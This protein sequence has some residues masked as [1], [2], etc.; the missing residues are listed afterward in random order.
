M[1]PGS[2]DT[3]PWSHIVH[4]YRHDGALTGGV[5]EYLAGAL[6]G[7]AAVIVATPAHRQAF[8]A[9]LAAAGAD[10][11]GARERGELILL[12][13]ADTLRRIAG[14][15]GRIDPA[16]FDTEI[17]SMIRQAAAV[18][19]PVRV[20]GEMVALLWDAGQVLAALEL[21]TRWNGLGREV[22]FSLYCAYRHESVASGDRR[23]VVDEVCRLHAGVIT[24]PEDGAPGR[25]PPA[26]TIAARAFPETREAVRAARHFVTGTLNDWCRERFTAD[27]AL[28]AT[29]FA[30]N[31]VRHAQTSFSVMISAHGDTIR[32]SVHDATPLRQHPAPGLP[33][34][35]AHG[36]GAVAT[37]ASRWGVYP[38]AAG[39]TVWAEL[40]Q[41]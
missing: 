17:G 22:P 12:D 27:A 40:Q 24:G 5:T 31:A 18:R 36:L 10:V 39:K 3:S 26:R 34:S 25:L 14:K 28:V 16:R 6:D 29:E 11:T 33:V 7:G 1:H 15:P 4:F 38:I 41:T 32:I 37:I 9:S 35:P 13:A 20:Y 8:E 30:A 21:E 2:V 19:R 23:G